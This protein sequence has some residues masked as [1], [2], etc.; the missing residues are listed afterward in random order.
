MK[1]ARFEYTAPAGIEE[2]VAL[3]DPQDDGQ[4][5]CAGSQ[6]LGPM[7]NLRL[8]QP[9]AL[10]DVSRV[11]ALREHAPA[12]EGLRIGAAVTHAEIE[13]GKLPDVTGGLLPFVAGGIAYRAVR[14]RG[15][16]GG[17]LAHADPAADWVSTMTLLGAQ[18]TLQSREGPR[19]VSIE[20][21]F[22]GPFTT[23]LRPGELIASV[24]VP[25]FSPRAKWS[26]RK[27][28]RKPGEFAE[29]LVGVWID[30]GAGVA[31]LVLGALDRMPLVVSGAEKLASLRNAEK[32]EAVLDDAGLDDPYHRQ[33]QRVLVRRSIEAIDIFPQ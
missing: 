12:G 20:A 2:A 29:A 26:Y 32:L 30:P 31:R 10:I 23:V 3:L 5:V 4:K 15:T 17:S 11:A 24:T 9:S 33:L 19:T 22:D 13:D 8:A 1:P 7:L 21:F 18:L 6:S 16:V 25:R 27:M 14:N 28:C